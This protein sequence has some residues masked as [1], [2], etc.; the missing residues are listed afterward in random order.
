A[1]GDSFCP[2]SDLWSLGATL[3]AAVEGRPP[4]SRGAAIPTLAAVLTDAPDPYQRA[5]PLADLL[6]GLLTK[7]PETRFDAAQTRQHLRHVAGL[8]PHDQNTAPA[9]STHLPADTTAP[10]LP[11]TTPRSDMKT[12]SSARV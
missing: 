6:T 11:E 5:G 4:F 1:A 10:S 2:A 12:P 8:W 7:N 3:Y 9:T